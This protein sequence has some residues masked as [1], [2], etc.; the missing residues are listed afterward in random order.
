M[1]TARQVEI[2]GDPA[3]TVIVTGDGNK[4]SLSA[5][6]EFAYHPLDEVFR[7][8]QRDGA[9]A[10]FYNGT[11]PNWANI[12]LEQDSPRRLI[13]D[14]IK[15][16][17]DPSLSPQ[18]ICIITGLSGEGKT[19]LIM[20]A[21][22]ELSLSGYPV[23]WRHHGHVER[24]YHLPLTADRRLVICF[25]EIANE[26]K[27][28]DLISDLAG[29][30]H[31]FV[32]LGS[33]RWHDWENCEFRSA[34]TRLVYPRVFKLDRLQEG[35]VQE[36]LT[37][38]E[39]S[40][41]L[42]ALANL[43]PERRM[44]HFLDRLEADGQLLPALLTARRGKS[45]DQIL[46]SVFEDL[47]KRHDN[48]T[49]KFLLRGYAG[50]ALVH[51]F[52]FG[53]TRPLLARFVGIEEEELTPHLLH[54]LE[55]ELLEISTGEEQQLSTRHPW[56]AEKALEFLCGPYVA[57]EN[58]LY[59]DLYRALGE[60]LQSDPLSDERK[61]LSKLPIA[62]KRKGEIERARKIFKLASEAAP[63]KART[64]QPWAM[65]E[66]ELHNYERARELFQ[67]AAE[68]DPEHAPVYHAWAMMEKKQRKYERARELLQKAA[69]ANPNDPVTFQALA[70][71]EK[72]QQKYDR[73]REL[74]KKAAEADPNHAHTYNAW[75]IME[76]EQRNYDTAREL[77]KKATDADPNNAHTYNAWAIMEKEQRN[78]DT[79]RE[80]FK[81][82]TD[83]DPNNAHTYNA[84]AIME[85]EQRNYDTARELFKKATD[86][87]PNNAH[88]YNAWAIM[89]KEQRNYDTARELFKKATDAD[90]NNAH[91]YNAWAIMEKEQRN[92]DTARELFKKATDA[93]PNNAHTYNAWAIMEKEQRNYDTA[94]ELFMK[95]A[96]VDP[97]NAH[98]Y[99]AWAIMEA[100]LTG[101]ETAKKILDNGLQH[102]HKRRGRALLLSSMGSLLARQQDYK[103]ARQY[104]AEA[105]SIDDTNALTHYHFA[106]DCL[107]YDG[108]IVE[109]CH[110]LHLALK[111]RPRKEH[112]RRRIEQAL[113]RYCNQQF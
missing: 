20:R 7:A 109:A 37:R 34:L 107:L 9:P 98:T 92:Y 58:Y 41:A 39:R 16:A 47:S 28:P 73:A 51:R 50:I 8:Q 80:L 14:I 74:F 69:D 108:E 38:L 21:A 5:H 111:L 15:F 85:K 94:R 35:E 82:A 71:M 106:V 4:V 25:D 83:A 2:V 88:T 19:T 10:D 59:R 52:N 18:R 60:L 33:A 6:E 22:W 65:M 93:D 100:R 67:L 32:I 40:D 54:P 78:Y 79:A 3:S 49:K 31:P 13:D 81:K 75:A 43:S 66:R 11:R 24:S 29:S 63:N 44:S 96:E 105:L 57:E 26:E 70:I 17:S 110:H 113:E 99:N 101:N 77:F 36:L 56:I 48:E 55:G 30:G 97:N 76:K 64:L 104:F 95:A 87:D 103:Q 89:E 91:T 112:D 23:L 46:E 90:P 42:G 45:F 62:F 84:W 12:A 102:V 53:M 86:A 61:L 72:E 27:L 1:N 68:A